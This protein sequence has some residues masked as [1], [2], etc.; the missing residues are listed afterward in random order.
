MLRFPPARFPSDPTERVEPYEP[1]LETANLELGGGT[2]LRADNA[3]YI[4]GLGS[5]VGKL[6]MTSGGAVLQVLDCA[7]GDGSW[8]ATWFEWDGKKRR[9]YAAGDRAGRKRLVDSLA[10]A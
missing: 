9:I 1:F 3:M 5:L 7:I 6:L 8:E 2:R 4:A 10:D